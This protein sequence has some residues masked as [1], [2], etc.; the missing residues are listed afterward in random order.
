MSTALCSPREM[1][2]T[3]KLR[4]IRATI[5]VMQFALFAMHVLEIMFFVGMAGSAVVVVISFIEDAQELFGED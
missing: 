2:E 5:N 4:V 3:W 1:G